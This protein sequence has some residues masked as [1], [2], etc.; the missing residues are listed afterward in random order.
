[1]AFSGLALELYTDSILLGT[2]Q[3]VRGHPPPLPVEGSKNVQRAGSGPFGQTKGAQETW[4]P[5]KL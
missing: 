5:R 1:M 4:S 3:W 2:G